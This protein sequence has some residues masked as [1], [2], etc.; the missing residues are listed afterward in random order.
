MPST[1]KS[2]LVAVPTTGARSV[3]PLLRELV[4]QARAVESDG[5]HTVSVVLLD[6]SAT[7]SASARAAADACGIECLRV[8]RKGFAQVRNAALEAAHTYAALVF[9]DD[10]EQPVPGWLHALVAT[11]EADD[12]DVVIGPVAV[13]LP[14]GAPRWL[15]EG[16]LIREVRTQQDGPLQG[17]GQSGNTLVR[18]SVVH[19]TQLRF[20]SAFDETGGEDAV[21]FNELV[22]QGARLFFTRAAMVW[23]TPDPERLTPTGVVRRAYRAG[24]TAVVVEAA[25]EDLSVPRRAV[26]RAGKGARGLCRVLSGTVTARPVSCM[27]GLQDIAFVGGWALALV[28][29]AGRRTVTGR[30]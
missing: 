2:I 15:D 12:A 25:I 7:G 16:R 30:Q 18:M 14:P 3:R 17:F 4:Q 21:F 5:T 6:N 13:R 28:T 19:R 9:I 29:S 20:D 23:E 22:R 8:A 26:R 1:L 11:A 10:D 27:R 24:R